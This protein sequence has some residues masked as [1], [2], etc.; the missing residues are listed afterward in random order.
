MAP[1]PSQDIMEWGGISSYLGWLAQRFGN[2]E[3]SDAER[4]CWTF[5]GN[6]PGDFENVS[7]FIWGGAQEINR[8][9]WS[10]S[11]LSN[12]SDIWHLPKSGDSSERL[13]AGFICRCSVFLSVIPCHKILGS[14][15]QVSKSRIKNLQTFHTP[16][17][18]DPTNQFFLL[19]SSSLHHT[20]HPRLRSVGS[21]IQ[22]DLSPVSCVDAQKSSNISPLDVEKT[23]G[24]NSRILWDMLDF[25]ISVRRGWADSAEIT[26]L[27]AMVT[28]QK[29][30]RVVAE[31]V[32]KFD[33]VFFLVF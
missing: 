7:I 24:K 26:L 22:T 25:S 9:Q 33:S 14:Y 17:Q 11:L 5:L 31:G 20:N 32:S 21:S 4:N 29:T 30:K 1:L 16:K 19:A 27:T 3:I 12:E 6:V 13:Q 15:A 23:Y 2:P 28:S 8:L 10:E 18:T